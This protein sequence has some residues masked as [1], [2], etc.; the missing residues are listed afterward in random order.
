M[1]YAFQKT[2][3]ASPSQ[4]GL[5]CRRRLIQSPEPPGG[6]LSNPGDFAGLPARLSLTGAALI[7]LAQGAKL[8]L[9]ARTRGFLEALLAARGSS[10]S[11]RQRGAIKSPARSAGGRSSVG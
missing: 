4:K 6:D 8:S 7:G 3:G 5:G 9:G 1:R 11:G 10:V 2:A